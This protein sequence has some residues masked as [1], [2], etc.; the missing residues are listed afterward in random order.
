MREMRLKK[1]EITD[2]EILREILESCEV[3]RIGAMDEEGMFI[4]PMNYGYDVRE[5]DGTLHVCLYLHGAKEGRKAAAFAADPRV[6]V[7]MDYN[8]EVI[9]GDYTCAY[10]YAYRSIM[11]NGTITEVTDPGGK[12]ERPGKNHGAYRTGGED[13]FSAG[14][15]GA[16]CRMAHRHRYIY[17]QRAQTKI[18]CSKL[19]RL[20]TEKDSRKD[21]RND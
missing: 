1:R 21:S 12:E 7:E 10:S 15:G 16:R 9:T 5:E 4:V 20:Q 6:A 19:R 18:E 2:P 11:G 13:R 17:R 14:D 8:H 3:V